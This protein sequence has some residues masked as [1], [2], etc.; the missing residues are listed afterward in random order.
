MGALASCD[1]AMYRRDSRPPWQDGL[2]YSENSSTCVVNTWFWGDKSSIVLDVMVLGSSLITNQVKASPIV[3]IHT[4]SQDHPFVEL[5]HP[6]WKFHIY[7]TMPLPEHLAGTEMERLG[8]VYD[9]LQ[10]WWSVKPPCQNPHKNKRVLVLDG[11]MLVRGTLS[12]IW[13]L[14]VPGAVDRGEREQSVL[15]PR[16]KSSYLGSGRVGYRKEKMKG[17]KNGGLMLFDP[18]ARDYK[19]LFEQYLKRWRPVTNMAEQEF[20]SWVFAERGEW[21]SV[22][23]KFNVQIHHAFLTPGR[24]SLK[25]ETPE[26]R[27]EFQFT[28]NDMSKAAIIHYSAHRKPSSMVIEEP[29]TAKPWS[30]TSAMVAGQFDLMLKEHHHRMSP[31]VRDDAGE[32]KWIEDAC[33]QA[34]TYWLQEFEFAWRRVLEYIW[35][36]GSGAW[37]FLPCPPQEHNKYSRWRCPHCGDIVQIDNRGS[38]SNTDGN[39]NEMRDHIFINCSRV[40]SGVHLSLDDVFDINLVYAL[41]H[42][43]LVEKLMMYMGQ[44][45]QI[46]CHS[47]G[48]RLV[49]PA[50]ILDVQTPPRVCASLRRMPQPDS[51]PTWYTE[52]LHHY[53]QTQT[54]PVSINGLQKKFRKS[55]MS[56]KEVARTSQTLIQLVYDDAFVDNLTVALE[57]AKDLRG[58]AGGQSRVRRD[59][60]ASSAGVKREEQPEEEERPTRRRERNL[61]GAQALKREEQPEEER[62]MPMLQPTAKALPLK[63][64][65][66]P[67]AL[68]RAHG[69]GARTFPE[70]ERRGYHA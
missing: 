40:R 43:P 19:A 3:S 11:D 36:N 48:M 62:P 25:K 69:D 16:P 68:Q 57:V 9:K 13:S 41:P 34:H 51:A 66:P 38:A 39:F 52:A 24:R 35:S 7:E 45:T 37:E 67:C 53:V 8:G 49:H 15:N 6:F 23:K 18:E 55:V 61:A 44:L 1:S 30:T 17:G 33:R 47:P 2:A 46:W 54:Q 20:L 59:S 26:T 21:H 60:S 42:G 4:D 50:K 5:F 27:N 58:R 56:I 28:L 12:E 32:M 31:S 65:P 10:A 70:L 64:P 63:R 29:W 14:G 22:P